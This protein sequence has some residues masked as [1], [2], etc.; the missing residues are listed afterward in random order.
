[1][2]MSLSNYMSVIWVTLFFPRCRI[3]L[4]TLRFCVSSEVPERFF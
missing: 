3:F 2:F 1:M 4:K